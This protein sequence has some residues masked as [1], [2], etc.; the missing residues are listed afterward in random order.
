VTGPGGPKI[1][2]VDVA[3]RAGTSTA[4]VSY[5]LNHGPRP[6]A[7]STEARV[8]A[9]IDELGYR[10]DRIA[11][12][13]ATRR[14]EAFG[15]VV[16]DITNPFISDLSRAIEGAASAHGH[17]VLLANSAV[18]EGRQR[19]HIEHLLDRRV[20]GLL[21]VPVGLD[22]A[23]VDELNRSGIPIALLD[24]PVKRLRATT[25]LVD[26][27]GG[28]RDITA[29]LISHGHRRLACIAGRPALYPAAQRV[30]GWEAAIAAA[31][32]T[33]SRCPL[34]RTAVTRQ[35]GYEAA[36]RLLSARHA[37]SAVFV[38]SDE[39]AFGVL[40]AASDLGRRV[41]DDLAVA[42]FDGIAQ[43]AFCVPG[44][45]TACQP[46]D[47]MGRRAVAALFGDDGR[48]TTKVLPVRMARRGSCGCEDIPPGAAG[49]GGDFEPADFEQ[50]V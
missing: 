22:P 33:P 46:V 45:T 6:V 27:F 25:I 3:R 5:V 39:Q 24:R 12:A 15:L 42:S 34:E 8:R 1:T 4:V 26:N 18:D 19:R 13:L 11:R 9:A 48:A 41:P 17:T 38:A 20:D 44:L 37:P 2:R 10:P 14:S 50:E 40:R 16:A 23:T 31:G 32:L 36:V 29:H 28:A 7:A 49:A 30:R 43:A 47:D 21:M 35:A